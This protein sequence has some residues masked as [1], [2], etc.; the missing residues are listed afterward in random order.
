MLLLLLACTRSAS[1]MDD[2]AQDTGG[3]GGPGVW[4]DPLVPGPSLE[5]QDKGI[6]LTDALMAG[7]T[8]LVMT[9]QQKQGDGGVWVFDVSA[10]ETPTFL[11]QTALRNVQQACWDGEVLWGVDRHSSL[12]RFSLGPEGPEQT[13]HWEIGG[14]DG[15][16]DCAQGLVAIARGSRGASLRRVD[17]QGSLVTELSFSEQT[18]HVLLWQD[19][20][21]RLEPQALVQHDLE[22]GG[23]LARLELWGHCRDIE[24][25]DAGLA[26]ACGS[27]GV[28]LI[29]PWTMKQTAQW[30]GPWNVRGVSLGPAG[31]V[32]SAW[33]H[34]VVLDRA[35]GFVGAEPSRTSA[36][37]SV[38]DEEGWIW[39]ADW[40]DPHRLDLVSTAASPELRITPEVARGGST[41]ELWNDGTAPLW[42]S[43]VQEGELE[44]QRIA[45]GDMARWALPEQVDAP[46]ALWSDDP[47]E[48][49]V[50]LGLGS[51]A[52]MELGVQ[53]P[54]LEEFDLDD[55][56]WR[57]SDQAGQV[58]WIAL[59]EDGCPVCSSEVAATEGFF[60][61]RFGDTPGL[62]R[63]WV[64][65]E[66]V[67]V[68]RPREWAQEADIQGTVLHDADSSV[69]REWFVENGEDA[70]ARNP[71]HFVVAPDG[72]L[73][74]IG[75]SMD[76]ESEAAV[77]QGL[78]D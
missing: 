76:L 9:G 39:V 60:V 14:N 24:A 30:R 69:R 32:A 66:G 58:V 34:T 17:E 12:Y 74:W 1:P 65:T 37:E 77:I 46:L 71:R 72:T 49:E 68:D 4:T 8:T 20:L 54:P 62:V 42:I 5:T 3:S 18:T 28:L 50:S 45:P 52:D 78:L 47:D 23:E 33:T 63:V 55:A 56:L 44:A 6:E 19:R 21:F 15:G 70:F 48:Q 57:L 51:R 64:Y 11:G 25:D 26:L 16:I 75:T 61:E 7:P 43:A 2:S 59:F 35:G 29:D 10:P 38:Q 27:E 40:S 31:I 22:S 41:V 36:M 67:G 13:G 73:A 53:A